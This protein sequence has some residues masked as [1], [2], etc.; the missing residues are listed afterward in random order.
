MHRALVERFAAG[1]HP[2]IVPF[3]IVATAGLWPDHV[4]VLPP[5]TLPRTSSGELRIEE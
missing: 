1:R 4:A 3:L 2:W 5:G